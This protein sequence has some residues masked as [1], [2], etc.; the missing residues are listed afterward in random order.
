VLKMAIPPGSV[1][2][3]VTAAALLETGAVEA[4]EP[5]L[6]RGYLHQPERWR[7]A[8]YSRHAFGHGQVTL[9]D[10][11][12]ESCNVY[13]F[14]HAG[15]LGPGPLTD[16][17]RRFGFG[18]ATGIDLA[19]E[20]AGALPTPSTMG[21]VEGRTWRAED[22]RAL[23]IGQGSL[24]ATPL[25]VVRMIAAVANDG[26]LVTPHVVS[27]LRPSKPEEAPVRISSPRG[28]P[29]LRRSTLA[30]IRH[31]LRRVVADV[32]G[33]AHGALELD[34]IAIAAK[35]GTA[36]T[37]PGHAAHAW[38]AGYVPADEPRVAFVVV[39]EHSGEAAESAGP[40]AKGLVRRMEEMGYFH[41]SHGTTEL[42][43]R[44]GRRVSGAT[45]GRPETGG[46]R[47]KE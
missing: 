22:T 30:T 35:T 25:Q 20:S 46:W 12:C 16:W 13:F 41:D 4:E 45:G 19:E 6:C 10:A 14:H 15:R 33:T 5:F 7:C 29:G 36:E 23:A 42:A 18:R 24:E 34:S 32:R 9:G 1:F 26:R 8:F 3:P 44:P 37:G 39:L 40:V 21:E 31:G 11:L 38:L 2:K 47:R 27:G 17:A 28:I 43:A